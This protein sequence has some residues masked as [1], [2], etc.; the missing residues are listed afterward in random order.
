MA[1]ADIDP[2][3]MPLTAHLAELRMRLIWCVVG[4]VAA[5]FVCFYYAAPLFTFLTQPLC[6]IWP[7]EQSCKLIY[8]G[9][10]EKFF[11]EVKIAFY[12]ALYVAFPL[13]ATQ[14]W[15]FVAPGLYK[16]EKA[17]FLPFL[18]ATPVMFTAGAAFVYYLVMPVAWSFFLSF[19]SG[20]AGPTPEETAALTVELLPRVMEYLD[21]CLKLI[22]AFGVAFELPVLLTLLARV[23]IIDTAWL[24][25]NRKYAIVLAFVAAAILTPPDPLSQIALAIPII[26]LYEGSI[27]A[28]ALMSRKDRKASEEKA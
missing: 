20:S 21:L 23:G 3:E 19:Q 4:M 17:A 12:G 5:F 9:L 8:T 14:L 7:S 25:S 15:L 28:A 16:K 18:I 26:L 24:K 10:T 11:S 27:W 13:I 22:M 6:Q 2:T 1:T